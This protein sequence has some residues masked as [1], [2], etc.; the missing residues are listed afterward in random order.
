MTM[1]YGRYIIYDI[2]VINGD[3]WGFTTIC[4]RLKWMYH[5]CRPPFWNEFC[6]TFCC[7]KLLSGEITIQIKSTMLGK[8]CQILNSSDESQPFLEGKSACFLVKGRGSM[9]ILLG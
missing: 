2:I 8:S 5:H 3:K 1:V 6:Q 9:P 4:S 7:F